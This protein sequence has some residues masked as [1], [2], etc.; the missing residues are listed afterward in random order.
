MKIKSPVICFLLIHMIPVLLFSQTETGKVLFSDNF[1][2]YENGSGGSPVWIPVKGSWIVRDG[3][4]YQESNEYDCGSMLDVYLDRSFTLRAKIRYLSGEPG[5]GFFFFSERPGN[6]AFSHMLRFESA[7]SFMFG[8]FNSGNYNATETVKFKFDKNHTY[9]MVLKVDT[10]KRK[11]SIFLDGKPVKQNIPLTCFAGYA[12]LQSS[13]G[14]CVFDDVE[15]TIK[16]NAEKAPVFPWIRNFFITEAGTILV[17]ES[18][19]GIISEYDQDGKFI[20]TYGKSA[21][22][23]GQLVNPVNVKQNCN[24]DIVILD[25]G[26]NLIHIFNREGKWLNVFGGGIIKN[27]VDMEISNKD[28]YYILDEGRD[29]IFVFGQNGEPITSFG[30]GYIKGSVSIAVSGTNVFTANRERNMVDVFKWDGKTGSYERSFFY[31]AKECRGIAVKDQNIYLLVG[32]SVCMFDFEGNKKE[33]FFDGSSSELRPMAIVLKNNSL[34]VSDFNSGK[35]L[36]LDDQLARLEPELLF[37]GPGKMEIK[38]ES[39]ND[40]AQKIELYE[41]N[42]L[43]FS[44]KEKSSKKHHT[45]E[46]KG[47][48]P[49]AGY[50]YRIYPGINKIPRSESYMEYS[51][52]TPPGKGKKQYVYFPCPAL[53]FTNLT[54]K[55]KQKPEYPP[56]SQVPKEE[57]QRILEHIRETELFYWV[58]SNM[59]FFLDIIPVFINEKM[60]YLDIFDS[61]PYYYPLHDV[62][63]ETLKKAGRNIIDYSSILYIGYNY[64]YDEKKKEY[65]LEGPG[66]GFTSGVGAGTGY[67]FSWWRATKKNHNSGNNWLITHEFNHQLDEMF[68]KSGHPEYWF[69][70]LS[71]S[72]G[73]VGDFGEHFD[74]NAFIMRRVPLM[75]W[76]DLKYGDLKVTADKDEDGIPDN[77]PGLPLDE[78]RLNSSPEKPDTD[79]DGVS[80]FDEVQFSNWVVTGVAETYGGMKYFPCLTKPDTDEDGVPDGDDFE[81]LVPFKTDVLYGD[82]DYKPADFFKKYKSGCFEQDGFRAEIAMSWND[83]ELILAAKMNRLVPVKFMTVTNPTGWFAGRDNYQLETFFDKNNRYSHQIRLFDGSDVSRWPSWN[84]E[85][86]G[87]LVYSFNLIEDSNGCYLIIKYKKDYNTGLNLKNNEILCLNLG[88]RIEYEKGNKRYYTIQEPNRFFKVKLKK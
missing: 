88:F 50:K 24:G 79:G 9:E 86:A 28:L 13:G 31:G 75:D 20:R 60:D 71:P 84:K 47:L 25:G 62:V 40:I 3:E 14:K 32:E 87:R 83:K 35:I 57:K 44:E 4:Y 10:E 76:F 52:T 41:E 11:Y 72:I 74:A 54:D 69:N 2:K 15:L 45:F 59:Q 18:G 48:A 12:G 51:F 6:T 85:L 61:S 81:P 33:G 77:S 39:T 66:G 22:K 67:G 68:L 27:T 42:S 38:S 55:R 58:T 7:E 26:T 43:I 65:Y 19:K 30:K 53:I 70:H 56:F 16:K 82:T 37:S 73:N 63:K 78:K 21:K 23:Y 29:R 1:S 64:R 46:I 36:I 80:D 49:S 5:A 34:Y 8:Y 17:P